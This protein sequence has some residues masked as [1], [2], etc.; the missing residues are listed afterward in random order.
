MVP[1]VLYP[2]NSEYKANAMTEKVKRL[3]PTPST[4]RELYVLSGNICAFPSC[5]ALLLDKTGAFVG[6]ICHIEAAKQ[7]GPRFNPDM[8]NDDRRKA[9]NLILLC[10]NHH[11]RVDQTGKHSVQSLRKMKKDHEAKFSNPEKKIL[12]KL[13]DWTRGEPTKVTNL[14]RLYAII[15]PKLDDK[16]MAESVNE[17]N[18][19]IDV[20]N[21]IPTEVRQ[22]AY[23]VV[24]RANRMMDSDVVESSPMGGTKILLSD[25]AEAHRISGWRA[26]RIAE[27]LEAYGIAQIDTIG[28][29]EDAR[30]A[31]RLD[32]RATEWFGNIDT[33]CSF[34]DID[35]DDF[36]EDLDFS[37]F[38][39]LQS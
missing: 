8:T 18:E 1:E 4:A 27:S 38:D 37:P 14:Q 20:L 23:A 22:Q 34:T 28:F 17:L 35:V 2:K 12:E 31:V 29:A 15:D 26:K 16:Q 21:R 33:F 13:T 9:S 7:G 36:I 11:A 5:E 32:S 24:Q 25:V 6:E 19:Y 30:R 10:R 39:D 3:R